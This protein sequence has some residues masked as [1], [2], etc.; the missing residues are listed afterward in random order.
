MSL[1]STQSS[2]DKET[3]ISDFFKVQKKSSSERTTKKAAPLSSVQENTARQVQ[4]QASAPPALASVASDGAKKKRC[5]LMAFLTSS[6]T[7]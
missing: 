7:Q 1:P 2:T 3:P 5:D 4:K 6:P